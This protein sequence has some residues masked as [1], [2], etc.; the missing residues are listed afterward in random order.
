MVREW[1]LARL[2]AFLGTAENDPDRRMK[3]RVEP[4]LRVP[5]KATKRAVGRPRLA[6]TFIGIGRGFDAGGDGT[7]A[8]WR[9]P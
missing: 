7:G 4:T 8:A 5:A 9:R 1:A 6:R 3:P 2:A